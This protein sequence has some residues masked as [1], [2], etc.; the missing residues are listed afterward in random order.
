MISSNKI[1]RTDWIKIEKELKKVL[2]KLKRREK[3]VM[4][5]RFFA[6]TW[7]YVVF[8]FWLA[9]LACNIIVIF[10]GGD[11]LL[12]K[13]SFFTKIYRP[14]NLSNFIISMVLLAPGVI[15]WII[16]DKIEKHVMPSPNK[17]GDMHRD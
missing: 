1:E 14:Y 6:K 13:W 17:I 11:G 10:G 16:A 8:I 3:T 4:V 12:A 5:L 9:C 7:C 2:E 15:S